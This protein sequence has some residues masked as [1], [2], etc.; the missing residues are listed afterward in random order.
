MPNHIKNRLIFT[1]TTKEVA[2]LIGS[3]RSEERSIDFNQIIPMPKELGIEIH[4]GV[5]IA[6]KRALLMPLR[7]DDMRV[8]PLEYSEEDWGHFIQCLQN[9]RKYRYIYWYDWALDNWGTKW[10]AYGTPDKR[11]NDNTIFF[12]TAWSSP[13]TLIKVLSE[14]YPS[15]IINLKY[16]SE[17]SG[18]NTGHITFHAGAITSCI[19]PEGGSNEG[20]E[21]YFELHPGEMKNYVVVDG[22]YSYIESED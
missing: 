5:E 10:N 7:F 14:K 18:Y 17:D 22:K 16:A 3:I 19:Q 2:E 15:V 11:D 6:A 21:I 20:Y 4:T 13:T 1:G 9:A 8:S 12:E